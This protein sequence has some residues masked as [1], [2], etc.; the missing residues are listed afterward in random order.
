MNTITEPAF[1][2]AEQV[3]KECNVSKS[4]AYNIIKK[5]NA[6]ILMEHP[7]ALIIPGKV[8]RKWYEEA[9][10]RKES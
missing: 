2:D 3:M 6:Q 8:N 10:L 4:T 1:I 7:A 9:C 5:M